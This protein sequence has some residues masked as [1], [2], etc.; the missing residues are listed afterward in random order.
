VELHSND[1]SAVKTTTFV[2][3]ILECC[4]NRNDEW[5]LE[6]RGRIEY[7]LHRLLW[8]KGQSYGNIAQSYAKF[9]LRKYKKAVVVFDGYPD[10]PTIKDSTHVRRGGN[11]VHAEVIFDEATI[12]DG[13]RDHVPVNIMVT[14]MYHMV[15]MRR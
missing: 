5:A 1:V 11:H 9:V 12:F 6:V 14:Y 4:E 15:T 13:K 8:T 10:E 3:S 7:L 2:T